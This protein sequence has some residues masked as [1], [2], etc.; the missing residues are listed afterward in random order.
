MS[1]IYNFIKNCYI[2]GVIAIILYWVPLV[3]CL[4]GYTVRT[5]C[6]YKK[7]IKERESDSYYTPTDRV[8]HLVGRLIASIC[9]VVNLF[10]ALFDLGPEVF[11]RFF[12]WLGKVFNVPLVSDNDEFKAK[13][14]ELRKL[15]K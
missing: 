9:P 13:R 3:F 10:A 12:A 14:E 11:D 4:Y 2:N 5:W 7:D 6:N 8:G 15:K 1:E